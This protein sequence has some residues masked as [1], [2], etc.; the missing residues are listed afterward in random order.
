MWYAVWNV[1]N[2]KILY[3]GESGRTFETRIKEH[4]ANIR[5]ERD[6][7]VSNHFRESN[8]HSL[9]DF[10][11][12][13]IWQAT[14]NTLDRRLT[15][16]IHQT[17]CL[18]PLTKSSPI[19][20]LALSISTIDGRHTLNHFSLFRNVRDFLRTLGILIFKCILY[21]FIIKFF[22]LLLNPFCQK[23]HHNTMD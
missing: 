8:N 19:D 13:I 3:V 11:A 20:T 10:R 5:H 23:Y 16:T 6:T 2:K 1:L 14:D 21:L 9:L 15:E 17:M 22:S 4:V 12:Q 18:C 7:P